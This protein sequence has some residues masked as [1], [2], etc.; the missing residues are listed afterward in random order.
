MIIGEHHKRVDENEIA[1]LTLLSDVNIAM[2]PDIIANDTI[3]LDIRER[4]DTTMISKRRRLS[5]GHSV[6]T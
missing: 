2:K 3:T 5:N 1:N 4:P 6:A